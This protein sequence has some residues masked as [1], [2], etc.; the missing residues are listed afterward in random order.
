MHGNRVIDLSTAAASAIG[1]IR[2]GTG[3]VSRALLMNWF[4][5]FE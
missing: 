5:S 1:L 4:R 2:S 3:R